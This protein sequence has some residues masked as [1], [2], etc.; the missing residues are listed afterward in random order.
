LNALKTDLS[1]SSHPRTCPL[2]LKEHIMSKFVVLAALSAGMML[3]AT[4]ETARADHRSHSGGYGYGSGGYGGGVGGYG[5]GSGY[6]GGIG[7]H[8]LH[9]GCGYGYGSYGYGGL[10]YRSQ[11]IDPYR[12]ARLRYQARRHYGGI[13]GTPGFGFYFNR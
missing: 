2:T 13:L 6:R 12:G 5:Y 10:P 4:P 3:F 1:H 8:G 7:T 11:Y 9:D